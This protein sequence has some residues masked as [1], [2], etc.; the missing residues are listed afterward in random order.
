MLHCR[1]FI[2]SRLLRLLA[3][4]FVLAPGSALE[5]HSNPFGVSLQIVFTDEAVTTRVYLSMPMFNVLVDDDTLDPDDLTE[6]DLDEFATTLGEILIDAN[7][8]I[9]NGIELTPTVELEF[10]TE[11]RATPDAIV[12]LV[13]PIDTRPNRVSVTWRTFGFPYIPKELDDKIRTAEA[14]EAIAVMKPFEEPSFYH[15]FTGDASEYVWIAGARRPK[16][17]VAPV[18]D[19]QNPGVS[20]PLIALLVLTIAVFAIVVLGALTHD[21]PLRGMR[22]VTVVALYLALYGVA[23]RNYVPFGTTT[24]LPRESELVEIF[25]KLLRNIYRAFDASSATGIDE[26]GA[27]EA[28]A[29]SAT[30]PVL[31]EIY[32]EV[33]ESLVLRE[34]G[35]ILASVRSVDVRNVEV[36][37]PDETTPANG[38]RV[39][40]RWVIEAYVTHEGYFQSQG[41]VSH[42]HVRVDEYEANYAVV[43]VERSWKIV[44]QTP[45]SQKR[46]GRSDTLV[47]SETPEG[48]GK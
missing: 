18:L 27:F 36:L 21:R 14:K 16:L 7:P 48:E 46:V 33:F 30:G 43:R 15:T 11:G 25:E 41:N 10:A 4:C 26:D 42:S 3:I 5:A 20:L 22:L 9:A 29:Q 6:G 8:L 35:G 47:N 44:E 13:Y 32:N 23:F 17:D 28:L 12:N 24:S 34:E 1:Q 45:L 38:F 39:R 40:A 19:T 31:G 2:P 37:A